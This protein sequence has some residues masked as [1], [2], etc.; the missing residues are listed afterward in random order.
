MV[1]HRTKAEA[2]VK[3]VNSLNLSDKIE[4]L[5]QLRDC[6]VFIK[7]VCWI[8]GKESDSYQI[9]DQTIEDRLRF[10]CNFLAR[11]ERKTSQPEHF[12]YNSSVGD[13]VS[14]QE[15]LYGE[16]VELEVAKVTV[17]LLHYYTLAKHLPSEFETLD[18]QTQGELV[19]ILRY[20]LDNEDGI[21]LDNN[22]STFLRS[23]A[24]SPVAQLFSASSDEAASPIVTWRGGALKTQ[25]ASTSSV[26][27]YVP[28]G[29]PTSPMRDFIRTPQ[30]Q[31]RRLKTQ[32]M[33]IRTLRDELEIELTET[34]K[35]VTEKDTQISILQQRI[36]RLVKLTESQANQKEPGEL[37]SLRES[38]ESLL[39]RLRDIQKQC[40]DLKTEKTQMERKIDK[41][42]E[43][44]G[45]LSYKVRDLGSHLRQSQKALNEL[46]DEHET[47]VPLWE[48]KQKE[49]ERELT[50][51][52][53]EKKCL[54][55][56]LQILEGK[57]SILEDQL[58]AAGETHSGS[59]GEVMGDVLQLEALKQE[60]WQL[61]GKVSELEQERVQHGEEQQRLSERMAGLQQANG[62]MAL[63][64]ALLEEA[65]R[66]R[67]EQLDLLNAEMGSLKLALTQKELELETRNQQA[68]EWAERERSA[69]NTA[70]DLSSKLACLEEAL[71]SKE[72][73]V[74][75]FR[76]EV[77][78][79][80]ASQVQQL[81]AMQEVS[82]RVLSE[83]ESVV[84][85]YTAL[86]ISKEID[87]AALA[88]QVERL[89]GDQAVNLEVITDLQQERNELTGRIQQLDTKVL[90]AES[91]LQDLQAT[92]EIQSQAQLEE[93]Q[94]LTLKVR[95]AES[96][97][98]AGK[99][100]AAESR[101]ERDQLKSQLRAGQDALTDLRGTLEKE[102][103]QV[104]ELESRIGELAQERERA[105]AELS[106]EVERRAEAERYFQQS[107]S[108]Q[109]E[110]MA[111]LQSE[112]TSALALVK[113]KQG[114]EERL[115]GE[116]TSWQ[117]RC[118]A[119]REEGARSL[120]H[121]EAAVL[122]LKGEVE[123][124]QAELGGER[125]RSRGLELRIA[126]LSSEGEENVARVQR[127]LSAALSQVKA[128]KGAEEQA[129][130][131]AAALRERLEQAQREAAEHLAQVR[132]EVRRAG[133]EGDSA[134]RELC[135]ERAQ[136][137]RAKAV[138]A[139]RL[140][141]IS[142]LE[143]D[144]AS[145]SQALKEKETQG[146]RWCGEAGALRAE[147]QE[148]RAAQAEAQ[149]QA[150]G[151]LEEKV[152]AQAELQEERLGRVSLVQA[153]EEQQHKLSAV[154]GQLA[155][156]L[157]NI[158]DRETEEKRLLAEA[159]ML[160]KETKLQQERLSGLQGEVVAIGELRAK[161][162]AQ[163]QETQRC[164]DLANTREQQVHH[165]L[166]KVKAGEDEVERCRH[167]ATMAESQLAISRQL[168]QEK[169]EESQELG[170]QVTKLTLSC[171]Q[172]QG[173]IARLESEQANQG[174]RSQEERAVLEAEVARALSGQKERE[175]LVEA[176]K[177]TMA[178]QEQTIERQRS[179][180]HTLELEVSSLQLKHAEVERAN[181]SLREHVTVEQEEGRKLQEMIETLKV[182]VASVSADAL[183]KAELL[184]YTVCEVASLKQEIAGQKV[185]LENLERELASERECKEEV[186]NEARAEHD[187]LLALEGDLGTS[188]EELA[189]AQADLVCQSRKAADFHTQLTTLLPLQAKCHEQDTAIQQL[190]A[191]SLSQQERVS[192]LQ[193]SNSQ[194]MNELHVQASRSQKALEEQRVEVQAA[195]T[196]Q[197]ADYEEQL[198]TSR[199]SEQ[200]LRDSLQDMTG[201]YKHARAE[202]D[203]QRQFQEEQQKL[204][205][206]L[207]SETEKRAE[208]QQQRVVELTERLRK[209]E[210]ATQHYKA[211][212]EKA[213]THYDSK[214]QLI[215]ELSEELVGAR[216]EVAGL[217][218]ETERLNRELQLSLTQSK[219]ATEQNKA[220]C[221]RVLSLESQVDYADRQVRERG[222]PCLTAGPIQHR[223]T[224]QESWPKAKEQ[225]GN[226]SKDSIEL[227]DLEETTMKWE[228]EENRKDSTVVKT[229]RAGRG[230]RPTSRE[231]LETL[232]FTPL[233]HS[234][235]SKLDTSVC[236]FNDLSLDSA[237]RTR[238]G[239]R[240]T[241]QVI[242]ILMTKKQTT[243]E[244]DEPSSSNSSFCSMKS[245][246]SHPSLSSKAQSQ[247]ARRGRPMSVT[248]LSSIDSSP[249]QAALDLLSSEDVGAARLLSLPGYRPST[250]G[251]TRSSTFGSV[252]SNANT[253]YPGSCQD[254]PEHL[255]DWNRIA[256]LQRRNGACPPHLKT[257]YPLE[258]NTADRSCLTEDELRL[259]DPNETLRRATLVP[260]QIK[261]MNPHR[262]LAMAF[263]ADSHPSWK[264]VTTRQQ[265]RLSEESHH[266]RD[267]PQSKKQASC[268][269]RPMT[270]KEKEKSGFLLFD[271]KSR[272]PSPSKV[273][274]QAERRKSLAFS[275]LNT[276]RKLRN[277]LLRSTCK[278]T[279]P[280]AVSKSPKKSP[281]ALANPK[282][283]IYRKPSRN[284]K[285]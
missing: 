140:A 92:F 178:A 192:E 66:A 87:V 263:T 160:L 19:A 164:Q 57:L 89:E 106:E 121:M 2:L 114:E 54:E 199:A 281:R 193:N 86:N 266:G 173:V 179:L 136:A 76:Q 10:V 259:G 262:Q 235:R 209:A 268:F 227:S 249:C 120:S 147:L 145:V 13:L 210:E 214:K 206:T 237:K 203:Y 21:H 218:S 65:N 26:Y 248:S 243:V 25:F 284:V 255:D 52:L 221:T 74:A 28:S 279:T 35:Q 42:E 94:S 157:T 205:Q 115:R 240:R 150:R 23:R 182:K 129:F 20:V 4:N 37:V 234:T 213:K 82:Q 188:R 148:L 253:L 226:F 112:L 58:K 107:A 236:S 18:T 63:E 125:E 225:E 261:D 17:L 68:G 138:E 219:E 267:T 38:N 185:G 204:A 30:V 155:R 73:A 122:Q 135:E 116:A 274:N 146:E 69:L 98:E 189:Q 231:S 14:C 187:R 165:L 224:V 132:E 169:L 181:K 3:W 244:H 277:S 60:V 151:A 265:K 191:Q 85:Q 51:V 24:T 137:E 208:Q 119:A 152:R 239:R 72:E 118:E 124:A 8:S 252:V 79:E 212:L 29:S 171:E 41:L 177:E 40:Q 70:L 103:Q 153:A 48:G 81:A 172:K 131:E 229:P 154:Q 283:D 15:F 109:A 84:L 9:E 183:K 141:R 156:A 161:L 170:A 39:T 257:S 36:D 256:E 223:E 49:L 285:M 198:A 33:D 56:K 93:I 216:Q 217:R 77:E 100:E 158:Q 144:I 247:A 113:Q 117:G 241:T 55:E 166:T 111:R 127:E 175:L 176:L 273:K 130:G 184:D 22:L 149:E 180:I 71:R 220:L 201:K 34:R 31:M 90:N 242:N 232:Y 195:H 16:D 128:R 123:R 97:V 32:L 269:P 133:E 6:V 44:N 139:E 83:K 105:R 276:P 59:K 190:Q 186:V 230:R 251:S 197:T 88:Q 61:K 101:R 233:P 80:R 200:K 264:G 62:D 271:V 67:D 250:H 78:A 258:S 260:Q 126:Q 12:K 196:L 168:C 45:D 7:M 163:E 46:A 194:L 222:A 1:L 282:K 254:E 275:V 207:E 174:V 96:Q 95:E 272:R 108:Q 47:A 143:Q 64:K 280:K 110:A 246:R 91:K 75:G 278:R 211:Q 50:G 167:E 27:S 228:N 142:A 102:K 159:E 245:A 104:T 53:I 134:R 99:G 5:A 162:L 215:Q 43:E 11:S 238:S 202:V 270:P